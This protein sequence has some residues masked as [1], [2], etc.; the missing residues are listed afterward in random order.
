MSYTLLLVR[1][2][3]TTTEYRTSEL[4]SGVDGNFD[5]LE[6]A[7]RWVREDAVLDPIVRAKAAQLVASCTDQN[8]DC[9][10]RKLF[11]FVQRIPHVDDPVGIERIADAG[12]TLQEGFGDCGDKAILLATLLGT[13]GYIARWVIV[14]FDGDV[15]AGGLDHWYLEVQTGDGWM[16]LDADA[17]FHGVGW[18]PAGN[19]Y[20]TFPIWPGMTDENDITYQGPDYRQA[21]GLGSFSEDILPGL[22]QTGTQAGL[23]YAAGQAQQARAGDQAKEIGDQFRQLDV[24]VAAIGAALNNKATITAAD[25]EQFAN[26]ILALQSAADQYHAIPF[27]ADLWTEEMPRYQTWYSGLAAKIEQ[28]QETSSGAGNTNSLTEVLSG[29]SLASITSSPLFV[30]GVILIGALALRPRG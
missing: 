29:F 24:Q 11:E 5:T 30:P 4:R 17:V 8:P 3:G 23:Q 2:N 25:L 15:T 10:I 13:L 22:I 28:A 27:V 16:P 1:G 21:S 26:G 7:A 18:Q 20:A 6:I 9:Q 19:A 12:T 14:N